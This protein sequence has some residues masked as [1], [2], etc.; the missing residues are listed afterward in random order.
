MRS[1]LVQ[2]LSRILKVVGA[3]LGWLANQVPLVGGMFGGVLVWYNL[4]GGGFHIVEGHLG[5]LEAALAGGL[6][7]S[8]FT[9]WCCFLCL[10]ALQALNRWSN[11]IGS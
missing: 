9:L 5:N 7:V 1:N 11:H 8:L 4:P 2:P 3:R 10:R 6:L